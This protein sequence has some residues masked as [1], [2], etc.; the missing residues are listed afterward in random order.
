MRKKFEYN[1]TILYS[2]SLILF[3]IF[4]ILL[5]LIKDNKDWRIVT[6]SIVILMVIN[7]FFLFFLYN[8]NHELI[9]NFLIINGGLLFYG[10]IPIENIKSISK[11]EDE[12]F[13]IRQGIYFLPFRQEVYVITLK[14]NLISIKLKKP[15]KFRWGPLRKI[16]KEIIF[17]INK[18]EEFMS[19]IKEKLEIPLENEEKVIDKKVEEEIVFPEDVKIEEKITT[20][21]K[22]KDNIKKKTVKIKSEK[23]IIDTN[24]VKKEDIKEADTAKDKSEEMN[25]EIK[26]EKKEN[27]E[28]V[29][30][31][32]KIAE[33]DEKQ[34]KDE[35]EFLFVLENDY[36]WHL[37]EG[38]VS[39]DLSAFFEKKGYNITTDAKITKNEQNNWIIKDIEKIYI[40]KEMD[41]KNKIFLEKN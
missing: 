37:Q 2:E 25:D 5:F 16:G 34:K 11:M 21:T 14:E 17:N 3:F 35:H 30:D 22:D 20:D 38:E 4:F 32:E 26:V 23:E 36:K 13:K 29:L 39:D 28:T 40:V 7:L 8:S 18:P 9:E 19:L 12:L 1:K 27:D 6:Y 24:E 41:D 15:Q 31:N 10:K 33:N